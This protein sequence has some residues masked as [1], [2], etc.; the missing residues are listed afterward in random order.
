MKKNGIFLPSVDEIVKTNKK[1]EKGSTADKGKVDFLLAK[2]KSKKLS[3]NL[4]IDIANIAS[5]LW[6]DIITNN[7]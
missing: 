6:H 2:I 5:I 1:L 7:N 3:G 4:I